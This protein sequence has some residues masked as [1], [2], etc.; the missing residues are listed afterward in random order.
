[1]P[2]Y[3]MICF[4]LLC[5]NIY[6]WMTRKIVFSHVYIFYLCTFFFLSITQGEWSKYNDAI[7]LPELPEGITNN[8]IIGAEMQN[9]SVALECSYH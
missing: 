8:D 7:G 5:I 4:L 2:I 3:W 1:V 9:R 6:L